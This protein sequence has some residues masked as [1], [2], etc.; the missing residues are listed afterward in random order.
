MEIG[1]ARL[2]K[3]GCDIAILS[4]G[5]MLSVCYEVADRL[6]ASGV[7][8]SLADARFAK[9]FDCE[10]V[11]HFASSHQAFLIVEESSPG[12]FSAHILQFMAV[13]GL[14]DNGLRVRTISLPD[15]YIDHAERGSQLAAAG[16]DSD[17]VFA[18]ATELV[19]GKTGSAKVKPSKRS[20]K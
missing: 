4:L 8:V 15:D 3:E 1:K 17:S 9:P 20:A 13:E 7:S 6:E 18:V 14:L 10:L 2:L 19:S 12:G 11:R 16:L 5:T